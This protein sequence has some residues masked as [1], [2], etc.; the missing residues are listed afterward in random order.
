MRVEEVQETIR[1]LGTLDTSQLSF[2]DQLT[3]A[4]AMNQFAITIKPVL[5]KYSRPK[6]QNVV[7]KFVSRAINGNE[8]KLLG[9]A[10]SEI[11]S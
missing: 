10:P 1:R 4:S 5:D 8:D 7:R 9:D 11:T 2:E 6:R 3:V